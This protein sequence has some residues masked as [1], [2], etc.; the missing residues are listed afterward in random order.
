MSCN[1]EYQKMRSVHEIRWEIMSHHE[2]CEEIRRSIQAM[3]ETV[4]DTLIYKHG[5]EFCMRLGFYALE[6]LNG[7]R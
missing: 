7:E 3:E 5:A 4:F 6:K 1:K 2:R